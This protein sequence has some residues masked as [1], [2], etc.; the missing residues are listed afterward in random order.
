MK[1]LDLIRKKKE[2]IGPIYEFC[3]RCEANLTLQKGYSNDLPYWV[4]RG[5][6]EM[7]INPSIPGNVAW[8]C[9]QCGTMLNVQ[10]NFNEDSGHWVCTECGYDNPV[11]EENIYLS[12]EEFQMDVNSPYRGLSEMDTMTL[13]SYSEEGM[14]GGRDD[15]ILVR[16]I[17]DGKLY[18]KKILKTYDASVYRFLMA[19]PISNM[20]N[21]Y[22]VF[23]SSNS[24]IIIEE[25]IKGHTILDILNKGV[26]EP[27][28]AVYI[29]RRICYI[30]M[31]LHNLETPIIHR[32]IKPSN[33]I[34]N[35]DGEVYLLDMNVAKWY[36]E[37]EIE[38]TKLLGTQY[39]AAPEQLGYGFFASSEKSDIYAL[40]ILLNVMITGKLPKEQKA[41]GEVWNVIEKCIFLDPK[42]RYSD[43]ELIS[44]LDSILR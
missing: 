12:E 20:P 39:Y 9:D 38:D 22:N 14:L 25:Y 3:T 33:V 31:E 35:E 28:K 10:E 36:K 1:L 34:I 44:A 4:C 19:H 7:L 17:E 32:D 8:I 23:E 43:E 24:L 6:G 16:N 26:L 41:D 21:I 29:T 30:L 2:N 40:G 11:G 27:T 5:C 15:I 37:N 13:L 42:D 18:V